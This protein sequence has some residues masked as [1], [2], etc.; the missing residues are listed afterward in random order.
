MA[1]LLEILVFQ[2]FTYARV[3]TNASI[4]RVEAMEVVA[5]AMTAKRKTKAFGIR[6][7]MHK[8]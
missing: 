7:K 3:R 1:K 4:E 2:V 5:M 8:L 6:A